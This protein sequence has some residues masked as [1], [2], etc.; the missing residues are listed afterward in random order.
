MLAESVDCFALLG[1]LMEDVVLL[2]CFKLLQETSPLAHLLAYVHRILESLVP[3]NKE[4]CK[5]KE[6]VKD[7][8]KERDLTGI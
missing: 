6:E 7:P 2:K 4:A 1:I 5:L 8:K 3:E